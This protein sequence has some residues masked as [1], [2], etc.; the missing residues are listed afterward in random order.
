MPIELKQFQKNLIYEVK[1]PVS[2]VIA[3]LQE[4]SSLDKLAEIQKKKYSKQ[5]IYGF[6]VAAISVVV[7][8]ICASV[9]IDLKLLGLV[10][11]F[12]FLI[13]IISTTIGIYA[14]VHRKKFSRLNIGNYRYEIA[15]KILQMLSRDMDKS[16]EIDLRL[17]FNT[18]S[19]KEYKTETVP[20]PHKSGWKIDKHMHEW[21]SVKGRFLDK[22]RFTISAIGISKTQYGWKTRG[23]KSKYKTKTKSLGLDIILNLTYPQRRYG[24]IKILESEISDAVKLPKLAYM[25]GLELGEKSMYMNV[26]VAPQIE[27]NQR[28]IYRTITMMFLSLYQVL[29]LAKLLSK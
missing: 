10:A 2:N 7:I 21:L 6:S 19:N 15:K 20:H 12:L 3:D 17:S 14:L 13:I 1:A 28:E 9:I 16:N 18:I 11:F 26:R 27:D 22:T 5:A 23:G 25:R 4:I 29:N 8:V 24:A